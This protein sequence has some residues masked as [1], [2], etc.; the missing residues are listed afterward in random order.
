MVKA[1]GLVGSLSI[2]KM[3]DI[4][5]QRPGDLSRL[6]TAITAMGWFGDQHEQGLDVIV[7][8]PLFLPGAEVFSS[9]CFHYSVLWGNNYELCQVALV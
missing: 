9:T 3:A 1:T 5:H 7:T 2:N 4:F 8:S 6:L